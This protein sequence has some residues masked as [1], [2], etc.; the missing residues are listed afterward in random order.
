MI[1][2]SEFKTYLAEKQAQLPLVNFAR[3]VVK[4][5]E[6]TRFLQQIKKTDNQIFLGVMPDA[7]S[8]ARDED[9]VR[10]NNATAFMFLE[11]TDYSPDKHD[12]W[13]DVFARTQESALAFA[14]QLIQDKSFGNCDFV[15]Y[16]DVNNISIEPVS[17]LASCNGWTVEVYFNIP[18]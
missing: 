9:N 5:A 3:V 1:L 2:V 16:L 14:K 12:D 8:A 18:F 17:D 7:R 10:M 15:R 4:E 11:K 13:L 6:V